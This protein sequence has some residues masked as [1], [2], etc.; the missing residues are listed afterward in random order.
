MQGGAV[1]LP[2]NRSQPPALCCRWHLSNKEQTPPRATHHL[3][4]TTPPP[5]TTFCEEFWAQWGRTL[6]PW[7]GGWVPCTH[8]LT[9][10]VC[11]HIYMHT[12]MHAHRYTPTLIGRPIHLYR[13]E[14]IYLGA[15]T[16][17]YILVHT[18]PHSCFCNRYT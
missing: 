14:H 8:P 13:N 1:C 17:S 9:A 5:S 12:S 16:Y 2:L 6:V 4:S 18:H 7:A 3:S 10:H 15:Y 11:T